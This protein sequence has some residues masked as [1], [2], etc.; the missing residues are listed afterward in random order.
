MADTYYNSP[1][2]PARIGQEAAGIVEAVG[3]GVTRFK[4]GD[5]VSSIVQEN[6]DYCVG[7][8]FAITPQEYLVPWATGFDA[9]QACSVWSGAIT[10]YYPLVELGKVQAGDNVLITAASSTSGIGA[11]QMAKMLGAR[12]I[13]TSRTDAKEPF[14]REQGADD[15]I[16]TDRSDVGKEIMR[17]TSGRG[18]RV[19]LDTVAGPFVGKYAEGLGQFAQVYLIGALGGDLQVS[20][21]ILHLVRTGASVTGYS[22]YNYHRNPQMLERGKTFVQRG[23]EE[24]RIRPVIDRVFNFDESIKAYGYLKSGVQRGKVVVRVF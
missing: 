11:I 10:A 9:T 16:P 4:A 2:F 19:V 6:N 21:S 23:L 24:G 5:R 22:I 8:E 13:A 12:V 3:P 14:L 7:G 18:V 15:V 1:R 20:C 17:L